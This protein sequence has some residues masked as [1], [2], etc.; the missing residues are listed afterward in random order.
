MQTTAIINQ[1]E[2][3]KQADRVQ[4]IDVIRGVAVLGILLMNIITFGI[5]MD[6]VL[7]VMRGPQ[8]TTDFYT[9]ATVMSL[10]EGTMR[11][12]FSMLFG[13]GILLFMQGKKEQAG[14]PTVVELYYC[15]LLWLLLFGLFNAFVLLWEGDIL[16]HYAL[17]GMVLFVFRKAGIRWLFILSIASICVLMIKK[18]NKWSETKSKRVAYLEAL[19]AEKDSVKLTE[20]QEMAKAVWPQVEQ[21]GK[22]P[23]DS[24]FASQNR[25]KMRSGYGAVFTH[26]RQRVA[27]Y[28]TVDI[29]ENYFWDGLI[30][31]FLGMALL[32]LGFF[33]N[34]LS[35]STYLLWLLAGY[36]IGI[37]LGYL[38]FR[39]GIFLQFTD[40]VGYVD[41]YRVVPDLAY[42]LRRVLV[43]VGHASLIMLVYRSRVASWFMRVLA[44]AG[45]MAFT[46]YLMQSILCT[47]LFFG[48]G[49]GW[50]D[51]LKL[52]QLYY[53]VAAVW[54]F[55]LVYSSI[56]LKYFRFGPFEWLW[57]S[58]TYWKK[59][60]MKK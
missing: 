32:R 56:W 21:Q 7:Q 47:F 43:T 23:F 13:A 18:Q 20:E 9:L 5:N 34:Q 36:G 22:E 24:A 52:Y 29:Y 41:R 12:L 50:Y 42:D 44:N 53:V 57:R 60:P 38:F 11:G 30:M 33:S 55:Q 35:T 54:L 3:V 48:Y 4:S 49:F 58:L 28:Q 39:N 17:N 6:H 2:P 1:P 59:Q 27:Y 40:F 10:F 15:R 37:P 14:G 8:T 46:N 31:M 26:L 45:Q 25:Q 19:M 16:Y 51:S